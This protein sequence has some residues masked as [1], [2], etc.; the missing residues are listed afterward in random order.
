MLQYQIKN[1]FSS[2]E[3]D[4]DAT[5]TKIATVQIESE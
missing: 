5:V 4:R 3:L 1:I 2:E